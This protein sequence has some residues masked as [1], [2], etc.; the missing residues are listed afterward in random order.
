MDQL[1]HFSKWTQSVVGTRVCG[2]QLSANAHNNKLY[3]VNLII[4]L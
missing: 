3:N 1:V 2:A 4:D